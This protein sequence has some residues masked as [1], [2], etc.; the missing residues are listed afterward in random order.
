MKCPTKCCASILRFKMGT[1]SFR[2][3]WILFANIEKRWKSLLHVQELSLAGKIMLILESCKKRSFKLLAKTV[4]VTASFKS[5]KERISKR[6]HSRS[7]LSLSIWFF[8][9]SPQSRVSLR[10][11]AHEGPSRSFN[12]GKLQKKVLQTF[13]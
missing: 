11:F 1:S 8:S 4:V 12:I 3:R 6:T 10:I 2:C 13:G 5:K 7:E 9:S